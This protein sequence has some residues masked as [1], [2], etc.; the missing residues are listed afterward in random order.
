MKHL[1]TLL[2]SAF[3]FVALSYP[4]IAISD[5]WIID[6]AAS[7]IEFSL[8]QFTFGKST[9]SF[10]KVSGNAKYNG[11]SLADSAVQANVDISSIDTKNAKRDE[12][13]RT[14]DFFYVSKYPIASFTS[15][16]VVPENDK[17][18]KIIGT[19][20]MHGI[21]KNVT[22]DAVRDSQT[23]NEM[24]TTATTSIDRKDF[25]INYGPG[26]LIGDQVNLTLKIH[27]V[28]DGAG[29]NISMR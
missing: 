5:N 4:A 22:L 18:F 9:G 13:L 28:R 14:K 26:P 19:L 20:T 15:N 23:S 3:S 24:T 16:K 17:T 10:T 29:K 2:M 6:P 1:S 8:K 25:G 21:T 27:L 7:S 12:H 11:K